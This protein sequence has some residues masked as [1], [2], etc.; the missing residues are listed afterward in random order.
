MTHDE[1]FTLYIVETNYKDWSN[2]VEKRYSEFLELHREM[3]LLRKAIG[4]LLPKFPGKHVWKTFRHSFT[5]ED[6]DLRRRHL[7][8]YLNKLKDTECA[9]TSQYFPN[10]VDMPNEIRQIWMGKY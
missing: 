2:V 6:I 4:G 10:F 5:A 3:K 1:H 9:H 8:E 7:Q